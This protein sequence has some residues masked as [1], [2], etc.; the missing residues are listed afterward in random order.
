LISLRSVF[1]REVLECGRKLLLTGFSVFFGVGTIIQAVLGILITMLYLVAV[2]HCSP[3]KETARSSSNNRLAVIDHCALLVVLLQVIMIK[4]RI[5]TDAIPTPAYKP[6]YDAAFVDTALV[7][8]VVTVGFSGS[9]LMLKDLAAKKTVPPTA[10]LEC[11]SHSKDQAD[12]Q[13]VGV[14][15]AI[16]AARHGAD[17]HALTRPHT[18]KT[19]V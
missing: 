17:T 5:T 18:T 14:E 16:Q 9:I 15:A 11:Y 10:E 4:Y 12:K 3:Y 2:S 8:T 7:L 1:H 19:V 13:P 6:G